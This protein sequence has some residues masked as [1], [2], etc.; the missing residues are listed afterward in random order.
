MEN[1]IRNTIIKFEQEFLGRG[2]DEVRALVARDLVV[3]RLKGVL[4]P[5]ERQ[6][7][8]N[9][10]TGTPQSA[11]RRIMSNWLASGSA[12]A[13]PQPWARKRSGRAAV[14]LGSFCRNDPAAALRGLAKILPS[15][16]DCSALSRGSH[17]VS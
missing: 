1:A 13:A 7:A 11:S 16:A 14:T 17:S 15:I 9:G 5:A 3:V 4:T 8:S 2:P 6:L 10:E 12:L